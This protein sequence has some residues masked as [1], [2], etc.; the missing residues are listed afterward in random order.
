[1]KKTLLISLAA[2]LAISLAVVGCGGTP[3]DGEYTTIELV[4]H[5]HVP[6]G[7]MFNL[8]VEWFEGNVTAQTDGAVTFENHFLQ[9][10]VSGTEAAEAMETGLIDFGM[11]VPAYTPSLFPLNF[12]SFAF[13]FKPTSLATEVAVEWQLREEFP[14]AFSKEWDDMGIKVLYLGGGTDYGI[15]ARVPVGNL[16]DFEGLRVAQLGG[17]FAQWTPAAGIVP[18][19][20]LTQPERYEQLRTGVIDGSLLPPSGH[21][22]G[23]EYEVADH[24][25]MLGIGAPTPL[26]QCINIDV[27]NSLNEATQNVFLEVAEQVMTDHAEA[28]DAALLDD[29]QGLID[30]GVTYYGYLT[31]NETATWA[32]ACPDTVTAM[33]ESLE[34]EYPEIWDIIDRKVCLSE[35]MGHVWPSEFPAYNVTCS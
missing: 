24:L 3:P 5:T 29:I 11:L 32:A 9:T 8:L 4:T 25:I 2:V 33:G 16:T 17:Y 15:L 35:E 18:V 31:Q 14:D 7:S 20:G 22:D 1:M 6:Q 19:T 23:S 28:S 10:L 12:A 34:A 30:N 26:F 27:W 21:L 13:P